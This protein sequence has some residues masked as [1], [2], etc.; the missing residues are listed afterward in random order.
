MIVILS[1][2][3]RYIRTV[4]LTVSLAFFAINGFAATYYISP[5]GSDVLGSG[6]F[7]N[8]W[9]TLFFAT[10]T[11]TT[12]GDIIHVTAGTY[13]ETQTCYLAIGV[14]IEGDGMTTSIVKSSTTGQYSAFLML[15]SSVNGTAGNQSISNITFDGQYVSEANYKTWMGIWVIA[16]NNVEIH[17]TKIINFYNSAVIFD[18]N[19]ATDPTTEPFYATGNSFHDCTALNSARIYGSSGSGILSIGGQDS[20][21][22]YNNTIIQDQRPDFKNGWPIKLWDNGWLKGCR[23]NNNVL[24]KAPYVGTYPGER[25]DWDFAIEFFNIKGL[26]IDHNTIQGSIDLNYNSKGTYAYSAWIH[27]NTMSRTTLNTHFESGIIF[28][29]DTETAI[30]ENN[31]LNNISN[32]VSFNTRNG[33]ILSNCVIGKNMFTNLGYGIGTGT[34]GGILVISEGTNNPVI[35]NLYIYQNTITAAP[36]KEPYVGIDLESMNLGSANGVIIRNNIIT[37]FTEAFVKGSSPTNMTNVVIVHNQ[38]TSNG[39][40]NKPLWPGGDPTNYTYDYKLGDP[41]DQNGINFRTTGN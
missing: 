28:E 29:F 13:T 20:M 39:N 15:E 40:S 35:T 38:V 11:V 25:G 34:A 8:P 37:G 41:N 21:Q 4:S 1:V 16:R 10:Q 6:N 19:T 9:K 2:A 3:G 12:I 18:G 17:H 23:I 30:V 33:T 22:V 5:T 32:G 36:G 24:T 7:G 27:H 14:S 26:E 31:V